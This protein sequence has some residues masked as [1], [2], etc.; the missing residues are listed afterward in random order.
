MMPFQAMRFRSGGGAPPPSPGVYKASVAAVNQSTATPALS[1][2]GSPV[3][4]DYLMAILVC[5]GDRAFTIPGGWATKHDTGAATS[6]DFRIYVVTTPYVSQTSVTFTQS[7]ASACGFQLVLMSKDIGAS[8]LILS[9]TATITKANAS[10]D[11]IAC[12]FWSGASNA[13]N[14]ITIGSYTMQS[15]GSVFQTPTY[16]YVNYLGYRTGVGAGSTS[17]VAS[18]AIG[19]A[20]SRWNFICEVGT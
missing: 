18:G 4:G 20:S 17:A 15:N 11:L 6:A 12:T 16:F 14:T 7:S 10:S 5:R 3:A 1:V 2:P 13:P 19:G 9:G 8:Q